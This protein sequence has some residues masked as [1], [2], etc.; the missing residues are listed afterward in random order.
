MSPRSAKNHRSVQW[1]TL[2]DTPIKRVLLALALANAVM[3]L[4]SWNT[5]PPRIAGVMLAVVCVDALIAL[6]I[7]TC[8]RDGGCAILSRVVVWIHVMSSALMLAKFVAP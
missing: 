6:M 2:V 8:T 1:R 4:C 5:L 7:A 3:V